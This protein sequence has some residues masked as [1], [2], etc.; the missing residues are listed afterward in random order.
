M[1]AAGIL[2]CHECGFVL[3]DV[4]PEKILV[5]D[6]SL[7]LSACSVAMDVRNATEEQV[8]KKEK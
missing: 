5:D 2:A 7:K 6:G 1:I 8:K 3:R 4:R